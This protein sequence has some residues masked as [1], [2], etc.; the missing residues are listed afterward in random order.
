VTKLEAFIKDLQSI[1]PAIDLTKY[2]KEVLDQNLAMWLSDNPR[3]YTHTLW[4]GDKWAV[5]MT[6]QYA[7]PIYGHDPMTWGFL[8]KEV[9]H[10]PHHELRHLLI[11]SIAFMSYRR[12]EVSLSISIG[13][14]SDLMHKLRKA[15]IKRSTS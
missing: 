14:I 7:R 2:S 12:K 13:G 11:A 3:P 1:A 9:V 6:P 15:S 5:N 8:L 4:P 10:D